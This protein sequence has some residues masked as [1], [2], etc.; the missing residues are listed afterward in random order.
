[1]ISAVLR[2]L[3]VELIKYHWEAGTTA[4]VP[5]M[6]KVSAVVEAMCCITPDDDMWEVTTLGQMVMGPR[7]DNNEDDLLPDIED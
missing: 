1:M 7:T 2:R 4:L 3:K 6:E 5:L